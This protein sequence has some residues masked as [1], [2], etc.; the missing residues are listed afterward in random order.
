ME[1]RERHA[2]GGGTV[3]G[4]KESGASEGWSNPPR[5]HGRE[6]DWGAKNVQS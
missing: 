2:P 3:L 1:G 6:D 5:G 4:G